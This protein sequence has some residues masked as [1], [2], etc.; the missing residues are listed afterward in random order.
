MI[1][2]NDERFVLEQIKMPKPVFMSS[3]EY[4]SQKDKIKLDQAL[5]EIARED[6]SLIIK[7]DEETGQ[8]LISG[9]GELH[10]EVPNNNINTLIN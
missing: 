6:S 3:L 10:L 8:I 7:D 1:E 4:E 9:L 5:K 2:A